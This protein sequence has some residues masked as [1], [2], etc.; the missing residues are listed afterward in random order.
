MH[1]L[2]YHLFGLKGITFCIELIWAQIYFL[3][4][5]LFCLLLKDIE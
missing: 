4:N 5:N 3:L 2:L 1:F